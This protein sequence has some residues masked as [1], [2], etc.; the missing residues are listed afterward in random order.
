MRNLWND[1]HYALRQLRKSPGFT[2]TA[3][4]TLAMGIGATVAIF[5]MM[6]GILLRPLPFK[7]PSELFVLS[8]TLQG[9]QTGDM[10]GEVGVTGPEIAAYTH[11]TRSFVS[12]GS[13]KFIWP[14]QLSYGGITMPLETTLL[15]ANLFSTLGIRPLMGRTFTEKENEQGE[16]VVVLG[17]LVWKNVFHGDSGILGKKI[18]LNREPYVVIG[19]M[20]RGLEFPIGAILI[21]LHLTQDD[22]TKP[23]WS[24]LE[25]IGRLRPGI[26]P[27]QA[28]ADANRVEQETRRGYPAEVATLRISSVVTSMRDEAVGRVRPLIRILFLAVCV[29]L[30][31]ACMNLAGLLLVRAM[32]R[33]RETAVRLALGSSIGTLI[34]QALLEGLLLSFSGA[35]LGMWIAAVSVRLMLRMIPETMPRVEGVGIH[36]PVV[37]FAVLLAV[38]TGAVASVA[39]AFAAIRTNMNEA[40]KEGGRGDGVG[41]GHRSLRSALVVTEIAVA[42][43]LLVASGLLLRS[44]QNVENV[45]LGFNPENII[46]GIYTLPEKRYATQPEVDGFRHN[47]ERKLQ[48]LPGLQS[49]GLTSFFPESQGGG[50]A[51]GFQPFVVDGYLR[52]KGAATDMA[53][54]AQ[55]E[56]NYF[57]TMGI[58]L[59]RGRLFTNADNA[60]SQLV[61]IVNRRLAEHYWP[62]RNPLG[63]HLRI[64]MDSQQ[65]PWLTVV[66]EV[67]DVKQGS[68]DRPT[69]EQF[70]QPLEQYRASYGNLMPAAVLVGSQLSV[71]LRSPLPPNDMKHTIRQVVHSLD[72]QLALSEVETM[73]QAIDETQEQRRFSTSLITVFAFAAVMLAILG[74]YGVIAFSVALRTHEM[75]I[76]MAL[77][78]SRSRIIRLVLGSAARLA[79]AGCAIG[80][81]GAIAVSH[82]LR[83]LLFH[84]E[85]FDPVALIGAIV[86]IL[87]LSLAASFL[88]ARRASS[89]EPMQALKSE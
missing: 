60:T 9:V 55:V 62:G 63:K 30:L 54:A 32:R 18:T 75:A 58:P 28:Q 25:M 57:G 85:P 6:Y 73:Q 40:L 72:P 27:A 41:G 38:F 22:L 3:V 52:P 76:R 56:G 48:Q 47:L 16:H 49:F 82:L 17:Y 13:F 36:W 51:P 1:L 5:S 61:V 20:P 35:L 12:L 15:S 45:D 19:V 71:L 24:G 2:F 10:S 29:V 7:S 68:A 80:L 65:T 39:P 64:G 87:A 23:N 26:T 46:A 89:I 84:I 74:I 8:D 43:T 79:L 44:F 34:R 37:V 86:L 11:E 69:S 42:M 33:R 31:I 83:S 50:D 4:L 81:I 21:P 66:G 67:A 70:Y 53:T 88:P 77:G 78:S 14:L 59:Q